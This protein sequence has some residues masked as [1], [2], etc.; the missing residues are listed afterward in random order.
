MRLSL[1]F[2]VLLIIGGLLGTANAKPIDPTSLEMLNKD[3]ETEGEVVFEEYESSLLSE[4]NEPETYDGFIS[5][6]AILQGV[7]D[8]FYC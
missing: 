3:F 6:R 8:L 5:K 2:S 7:S 4:N 1:S